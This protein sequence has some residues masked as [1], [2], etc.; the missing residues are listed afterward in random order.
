MTVSD[1][2]YDFRIDN[3]QSNEAA[4]LSIIIQVFR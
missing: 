2:G 3:A 4:K 1:S